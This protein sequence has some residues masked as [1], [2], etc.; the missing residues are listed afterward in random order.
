MKIC[1]C[2]HY[3]NGCTIAATKCSYWIYEKRDCVKNGMIEQKDLE[4]KNNMKINKEYDVIRFLN[5]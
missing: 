2:I 4:Q 3:N 5:S 1:K